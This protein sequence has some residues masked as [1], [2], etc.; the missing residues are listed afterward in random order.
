MAAI[1]AASPSLTAA[2]Y[3]SFVSRIA[4]L[5]ER[6]RRLESFCGAR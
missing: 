4:F 1:A 6:R 5:L 2:S 3:F